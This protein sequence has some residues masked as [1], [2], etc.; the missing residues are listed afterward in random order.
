MRILLLGDTHCDPKALTYAYEQAEEWEC[1]TIFQLGDYGYWPRQKNDFLPLAKQYSQTHPHIKLYWLPGNHE[2]W[3][4]LDPLM[5]A[6]EFCYD[7]WG[8]TF[9]PRTLVWE[10]DGVKFGCIAG[11]HSIDRGGRKLG[12]SWFPQEEPTRVD[13]ENF[14]QQ[15]N[16]KGWTKLDVFLSH[17]A[18]TNIGWDVFGANYTFHPHADP[19]RQIIAKAVDLTN[20]TLLFHGHWHQS[21]TYHHLDTKCYSIDMSSHGQ[22][23]GC[24][25]VLDT[26]TFK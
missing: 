22:K 7:G 9:V 20:P 15:M 6:G 2:D 17:E 16:D 8:G 4:A 10:W 5:K 19:P 14:V 1:D 13:L 12:V 3:D 11:A 26:E 23:K 21:Y 24:F 18:P 25:M